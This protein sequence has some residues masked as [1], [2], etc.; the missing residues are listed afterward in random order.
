MMFSS[1]QTKSKAEKLRAYILQAFESVLGSP[2]TIDIRSES[3]IDVRSGGHASLVLPPSQDVYGGSSRMI[4]QNRVNSGTSE[5]VELA[6]SPREQKFSDHID[7]HGQSDNRN[8]RSTQHPDS[9]VLPERGRFGEQNQCRSLVRGKVSLAHVIQQAEGSTQRSAWTK[10]KAVSI[11]EKLEQENLYVFHNGYFIHHLLF[12]FM[13]LFSYFFVF[14]QKQNLNLSQFS[15]KLI[16]RLR[17]ALTAWLI[18]NNE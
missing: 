13:L 1:P 7:I 14:F 3:R 12:L 10:R 4:S 2:V 9:S 11:A 16:S 15:W 17:K 8:L 6:G 18:G 5:I